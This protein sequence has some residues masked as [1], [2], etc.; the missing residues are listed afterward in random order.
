MK[1][2]LL[3][4]SFNPIHN[5]HLVVASYMLDNTDIKE[6]WFVVSPHNPLKDKDGL[7]S[8]EK[9][10]TMVK[11]SI[12]DNDKM[13]VTDVE[14]GM[15]KPSY[16]YDTLTKLSEDY[17]DREFIFIC[18]SDLFKSFDKWKNYKSNFQDVC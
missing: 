14:F 5:G 3:F 15:K 17:E 12:Q 13:K 1:T 6:I 10:L 7:L 2:G 11:L 16:S 8:D 18:G 9:R 4:G